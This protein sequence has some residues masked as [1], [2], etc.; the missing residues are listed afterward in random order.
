MLAPATRE[1]LLDDMANAIDGQGGEFDMD[2][3]T[4]LYIARRA[5][6]DN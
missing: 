3:E 1:A 2:Y 5:D 6:R 4:H